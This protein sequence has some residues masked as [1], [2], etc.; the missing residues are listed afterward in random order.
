M[1]HHIQSASIAAR[2][3]EEHVAENRRLY[4]EKFNAVLDILEPVMRIHNTFYSDKID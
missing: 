3:D 2:E 4:R 1:S